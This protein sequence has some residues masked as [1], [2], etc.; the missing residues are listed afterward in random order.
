MVFTVLRVV[1][2]PRCTAG[3]NIGE[4]CC[5][6]LKV[7]V[8]LTC[9]FHLQELCSMRNRAIVAE[10]KY[11]TTNTMKM[12]EKEYYSVIVKRGMDKLLARIEYGKILCPF[13]RVL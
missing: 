4:G 7:L 13:Q 9:F 10:Y 12:N 1:F 11:D 8:A 6:R 5:T 3:T 2:L